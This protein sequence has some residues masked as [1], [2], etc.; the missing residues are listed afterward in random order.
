MEQICK[1][2]DSTDFVSDTFDIPYAYKGETI[3]I[4]SVTGEFCRSCGDV[5]MD[6]ADVKAVMAILSFRS[7][8]DSRERSV[9]SRSIAVSAF[10]SQQGRL[11]NEDQFVTAFVAGGHLLA[12]FDG[13]GGDAVAEYAAQ[14]LAS[15]FTDA[16]SRSDGYPQALQSTV[17]TLVRDTKRICM[18]CTSDHD[19]GSTLSV[20]FIRGAFA[21]VATLGDSPVMIEHSQG[22]FFSQTHNVA[23]NPADA[24]RVNARCLRATRPG[25]HVSGNAVMALDDSHNQYGLAMTRALGDMLFDEVIIREPDITSLDM[26]SGGTIIVASDGIID[27]TGNQA[28]QQQYFNLLL[29]RARD[30]MEAPALVEWLLDNVPAASDPMIDNLTLVVARVPPHDSAVQ[31]VASKYAA[32]MAQGVGLL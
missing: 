16:L 15:L 17:A 12:V 28:L 29:D 23:Q 9:P 31:G 5:A 4:P 22:R 7:K 11:S 8:V 10:T 6:S 2:C 19:P 20:V 3:V 24:A 30:G 13:H 32:L 21:C 26:S 25:F 1:K 18:R 14:H 27:F